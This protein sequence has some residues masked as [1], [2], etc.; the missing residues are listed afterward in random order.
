MQ[1]MID[2]Y[3]KFLNNYAVFEGR[4]RRS[5]YWYV[6]LANLILESALAIFAGMFALTPLKFLFSGI[7]SLFSLAILVPAITIA[8]RRLHDIGKS[9]PYLLFA[10]IP[11]VGAIIVIVWLAT[12][13]QPGANMY[14]P[15]P[16]GVNYADSTYQSN[17][18]YQ[19]NAQSQQND[20]NQQTT[21]N[22]CPQCGMKVSNNDTFCPKCGYKLK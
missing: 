5:D 20:Y 1:I 17:T 3:K 2:A 8:V 15:N 14:G 16:K 21:T 19:N 9:G 18:Y 10:L 11:I 6:V 7:A 22:F 4:T 13:S 12:D